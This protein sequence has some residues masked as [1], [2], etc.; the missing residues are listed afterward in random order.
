MDRSYRTNLWNASTLNAGP[1]TE[2][3]TLKARNNPLN[4]VGQ[5]GYRTHGLSASVED[6]YDPASLLPVHSGP[7]VRT[8]RREKGNPIPYSKEMVSY[9]IK[10]VRKAFN[11]APRPEL[12]DPSETWGEPCVDGE[13]KRFICALAAYMDPRSNG[14]MTLEFLIS[15]IPDRD[16]ADTLKKIRFKA[17]VRS[18][19]G[20]VMSED[21]DLDDL[22]TY[23]ID[24][25][26]QVF[27]PRFWLFWDQPDPGDE[28]WCWEPI[29]PLTTDQKERFKRAVDSVTPDSVEAVQGLEILLQNSGSGAVHTQKGSSSKVYIEKGKIKP[30]GFSKEPLKAKLVYVQK[31]PGDTR[32]A[33]VLTVPQ[34]NTIKWFEK[35][36]AEIARDTID[37]MYGLTDH[38]FR[39][40]F[41]LLK[42]KYNY[43]LCRDIKKDGLTK[44]RELIQLTLDV[45]AEKYP[46]CPVFE[47]KDI[48]SNWYYYLAEEPDKIL[49]PP[50]GIGLGMS[51]AI[52]TIIQAAIRRITCD[53]LWE[54]EGHV[55]GL[56]E[57]GFYHDDAV[58]CFEEEDTLLAYDSVESQVFEDFGLIKNHKKTF[59]G[60]DFVICEEYSNLNRKASYQLDLLY[61]PFSVTNIVAAK[62][63][64]QQLTMY[65]C[66]F[67]LREFIAKYAEYWGYEFTKEEYKLPFTLGGWVPATYAGVDTTFHFYESDR[68]HELQPLMFASFEQTIKGI[69]T[70]EDIRDK[71][72]YVSPL[73]HY[74]GPTINTNGKDEDLYYAV[75]WG[76]MH[77]S[78]ANLF[79]PGLKSEAWGRLLLKRVKIY[80]QH[81]KLNSTPLSVRELYRI[82]IEAKP[83][84]DVLPPQ[85][86]FPE[87]EWFEFLSDI[88]KDY[89]E[90][91]PVANP[92][93]GYLAWYNPEHPILAQ[94]QPTPVPPMVSGF[95]SGKLTNQQ[96]KS[97][98]E[99]QAIMFG[100]YSFMGKEFIPVPDMYNFLS[101]SW[102]DPYS[103][104]S[105][106][107]ALTL[108]KRIPNPPHTFNK[109]WEA[110]YEYR[111]SEFHIWY[112]GTEYKNHFKYCLSKFGWRRMRNPIV[113][114]DEFWKA[115]CEMIDDL[116][117]GEKNHSFEPPATADP[118]IGLQIQEMMGEFADCVRHISQSEFIR[119]WYSNGR[120]TPASMDTEEETQWLQDFVGDA[121]DL[122]ALAT[123]SERSES[124]SD[125]SV[126][127]LS[128]D[129]GDS[130]NE[131]S[132]SEY[133]EQSYFSAVA[134]ISS[135]SGHES[136]LCESGSSLY[137]DAHSVLSGV[138]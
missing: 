81:R 100:N 112:T 24:D 99:G 128:T 61:A 132:D 17:I 75:S 10:H 138:G 22:P 108:D 89:T 93:L 96:R 2:R 37:S 7:N 51:S 33:S 4:H 77:R 103:V 57:G 86:L 30:N 8:F 102:I 25:I 134:S 129:G 50:R 98:Q 113:H 107:S 105:A 40:R 84:T 14:V 126:I 125:N 83:W 101:L 41:I 9:I 66:E 115:L 55:E 49:N 122:S 135:H 95:K 69:N 56:I 47:Y 62:V 39:R 43:F 16:F 48:Y 12:Y 59:Q 20:S 6:T 116:L 82:Y 31:C 54:V 121:D 114:D 104:A 27:N 58:I 67:E 73:E 23:H 1:S 11:E 119:D 28:K 38:Q 13:I 52:T 120:S 70:K 71:K 131:Y 42:K 111:S 137:W 26:G 88:G 68:A 72:P 106:W 64:F 34:S 36:F 91:P 94:L 45:L 87:P 85:G 5:G 60:T 44:N 53:E 90:I 19:E 79:L 130:S 18:V 32:R 110:I 76:F 63:A 65:E 78:M 127:R 46:N 118:K 97:L 133:D 92:V 35:Q 123:G 21:P 124:Q 3:P 109:D 29:K 74:L 136:S 80:E 117:V 15:H